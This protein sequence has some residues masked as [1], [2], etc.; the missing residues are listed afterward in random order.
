MADASNTP[1]PAM[2]DDLPEALPLTPAEPAEELEDTKPNQATS[3]TKAVEANDDQQADDAEVSTE[4]EASAEDAEPASPA[5]EEVP[6]VQRMEGAVSHSPDE[7]IVIEVGEPAPQ[8]AHT[9]PLAATGDLLMMMSDNGT[10]QLPPESA[11]DYVPLAHVAFSQATDIGRTR[12][13]NQDAIYSFFATGRTSET[14]PDFGVFVVADGMG[15]HQDGEKASAIAARLIGEYILSKLYL[16]LL[17]TEAPPNDV[18]I[19]ELLENAIQFA[20]GK[21][22][23]AV[24]DGG[25]TVSACVLMGDR[26]YFGHVGDSRAY[27]FNQGSLEKL[28]RDHS[29]VQRLIE[30]DQLSPEDAADHPQKNVLY[31]ALGQ[32]DLVEVDTLTRRLPAGST[33]ILCS[34]GLW[35]QISDHAIA[36]TITRGRPLQETCQKLIQLANASGGIDNVSVVLVKLPG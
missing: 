26:G 13:N 2:P 32:N 9:T 35:G 30:L 1:Q 28:T 24:P 25:T 17:A 3:E 33:L 27:L 10:R 31:R 22:I 16:P 36:E 19:A 15:G 6:L 11:F 20:N 29:L 5:D 23:A 8:P 21:V 34:D 18:P 7:P 12:T 4:S 14:I